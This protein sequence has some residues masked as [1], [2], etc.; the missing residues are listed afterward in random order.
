MNK[1]FILEG[2]PRNESDARNVF[3]D[4]VRK[5]LEEGQEEPVLE[6]VIN[7]KIV[8]QYALAFEAEDALLVS[9]AKELAANV[10]EG[11]HWND[12]GM[13][14]RLKEYR[15]KNPDSGNVKDFF[16]EI[17]GPANVLAID[18]QLPE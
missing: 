18:V 17:I 2:Y 7:E 13:V 16:I 11:T 15:A 9:K 10:V 12:A 5:P 4:K 8:P 6:E 3:M 1:G 14:R